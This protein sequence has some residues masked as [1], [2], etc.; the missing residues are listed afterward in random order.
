MRTS[1]RCSRRADVDKRGVRILRGGEPAQISDFREGDK[2]SATIVTSMPP[3]VLTEKQ[4]Q[5]TL[6]RSGGA[7]R[8]DFRSCGRRPWARRPAPPARPRPRP[9]ARNK[10]NSALG[11]RGEDVAQDRQLIAACRPGRSRVAHRGAG[12]HRQAAS[13]DALTGLSSTVGR[14]RSWMGGPAPYLR[15]DA[16]P[17]AESRPASLSAREGARTARTM[18]YAREFITSTIVGGLFI[19]VPVYLATLLMLKGMKSVASVV[20]PLAAL[21]PDW[22]PAERLFSLLLVLGSVFSSASRCVPGREAFRERMEKAFFEGFP[23]TA[24]C[25]V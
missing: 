15:C 8:F 5:A 21:V 22:I 3:K 10:K 13:H 6:A 23:G 16:S 12:A 14:A 7:W 17:C 1:S 11:R 2:L 4:V 24:S 20:R 9:A 25:A 19:V 18:K